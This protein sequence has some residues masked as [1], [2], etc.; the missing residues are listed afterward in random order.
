MHLICN[1]NSL[2]NRMTISGNSSKLNDEHYELMEKH[3]YIEFIDDFNQPISRIPN[4]VKII[5]IISSHFKQELENLPT[6]LESLHLAIKNYK[7]LLILHNYLLNLRI[8][9]DNITIDELPTTLKML[10]CNGR[11]NIINLNLLPQQLEY[12]E[13]NFDSFTSNLD[14]IHM[15]SQLNELVINILPS[16]DYYLQN[17]IQNN[18]QLTNENNEKI[19]PSSL[20]IIL[21][22]LLKTII[23]RTILEHID[24]ADNL[25]KR[26]NKNSSSKIT[27]ELYDFQY[28]SELLQNNRNNSQTKKFIKYIVKYRTT[29]IS[30]NKIDKIFRQNKNIFDD[31]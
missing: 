2:L 17:N 9:C 24:I 27:I 1:L 3:N 15:P 13:L 22:P 25:I 31:Y 12:L 14:I 8:I 7:N 20:P 19:I 18:I 10:A 29:H 5:S 23:I 28:Q 30:I 26:F 16:S 6:N 11:N 4:N 21:N